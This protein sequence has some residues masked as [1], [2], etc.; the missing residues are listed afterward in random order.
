MGKIINSEGE[1]TTKYSIMKKSSSME[2]LFFPNGDNN[3]AFPGS[4]WAFS[5]KNTFVHVEDRSD[6][7]S[8]D[9]SDIPTKPLPPSLSI[10]PGSVSPDKLAAY[11]MDYQ[12]FRAGNA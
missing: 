1:H 11:R 9:E 3:D 6:S 10:I 7:G 8:G 2:E 4:A 12:K 5:V